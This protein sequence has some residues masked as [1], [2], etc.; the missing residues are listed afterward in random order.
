[1]P[2]SYTIDDAYAMERALL[3]DHSVIPLLHLP[4][5]YEAGARVRVWNAPPVTRS[6]NL[7]LENI[8]LVA[9]KL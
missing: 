7:F 3:E 1:M 2:P 9:D 8:W 5:M 4:E 6:G